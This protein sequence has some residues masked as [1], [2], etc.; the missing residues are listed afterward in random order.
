MK[1]DVVESAMSCNLSQENIRKLYTLKL[2]ILEQEIKEKNTAQFFNGLCNGNLETGKR[3]RRLIEDNVVENKRG[4]I[5]AVRRAGG[6]L[7]LALSI[8]EIIENRKDK[9]EKKR[10]ASFFRFQNRKK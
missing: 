9:E 8:F 4:L 1:E 7:D 3:L 5:G 10:Q 6:D 2:E